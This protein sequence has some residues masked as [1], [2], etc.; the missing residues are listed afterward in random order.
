MDIRTRKIYEALFALED[1]R[2]IFRHALPTGLGENEEEQ[3]LNCIAH[4][5]S[6]I[7]ELKEGKSSHSFFIF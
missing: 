3:F 5:E 1:L 6:I 4:T 2:E 7:N